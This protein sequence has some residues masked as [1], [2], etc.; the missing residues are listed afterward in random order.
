MTI[1]LFEILT[2]NRKN[3][4]YNISESLRTLKNVVSLMKVTEIVAFTG[5]ASGGAIALFVP[6]GVVTGIIVCFSSVIIPTLY[7]RM[8]A[9]DRFL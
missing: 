8:T 5:G 3:T 2:N 6:G 9:F 1:M 4:M 7:T